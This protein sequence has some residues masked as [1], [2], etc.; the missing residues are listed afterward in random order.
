MAMSHMINIESTF[1]ATSMQVINDGANGGPAIVRATG[2]DDSLDF[3]NASKLIEAVS[4]DIPL[5]VPASADDVDIPVEIFVDYTLSPGDNYLEIK[6]SVKNMGS[7]SLG[8]Y[9]GDYLVGAA[10]ELNQFVPGLGFGE[11]LA[12]LSLDFIAFRG[13]ASASGLAYG[14][15]PK[16]TRNST[17]FAETGVMATSLGQNVVSVLLQ[18]SLPGSL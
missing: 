6:T 15:I 4:G 12:R 11:P 16:I 1:H 5:S 18:E 10:G 9:F 8:L 3:I 13:K 2:V 14:Y 7:T 17:A